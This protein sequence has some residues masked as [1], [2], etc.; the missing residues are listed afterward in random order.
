VVAAFDGS[1]SKCERVRGV[2]KPKTCL[3][4]CPGSLH[5]FGIRDRFV[6]VSQSTQSFSVRVGE[7]LVSAT[8]NS[9]KL[10]LVWCAVSG[11]TF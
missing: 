8:L 10:S 1:A 5:H 4:S 6:S 3:I 7:V 2:L 11:L 9:S